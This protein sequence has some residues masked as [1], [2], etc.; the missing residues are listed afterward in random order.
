MYVVIAGGGRIGRHIAEDQ[1]SS[2]NDVTVIERDAKRC[3]ALVANH[4]VLV[5]Q[6]DAG[7]TRY[8]EQA[9]LDR[10]DV[11]VATTHDDEENLVACQLARV[12]FGVR[13][14][15][16]RV[17]SPKNVAIFTALGIEAVSST[18]LI[19]QLLENEFDVGEL[20][21]LTSLRG[22]K[23]SL[24]EVRIPTEENA[25]AARFVTDLTLPHDVVLVAIFRK[26]AI[27]I[28]RGTTQILPGDEVVALTTPELES[29]L[30][31]LLVGKG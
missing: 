1:V 21:H 8:L 28:P 15:I 19:S 25:P 4:P 27:I 17:N 26:E 22:G 31:E 7:D 29:R 6:G 10:A 3:E 5:I 23:V 12:E 2:G 9:H 18:Q 13:R 16:S 11:F 30:R 24:V 20:V 14:T